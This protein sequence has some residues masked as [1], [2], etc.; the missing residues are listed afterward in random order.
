MTIVIATGNEGKIA[1]FERIF[2]AAEID[3]DIVSAKSVGIDMSKIEETGDSF[4]Q[5]A[6]IKASDA[7]ALCGLPVVADD[8]GLC[9]DAIGGEPGIYSARYSGENATDE[10]NI[11]KLLLK[12][13]DIPDEK[14]TARFYCCICAV[15]D[16]VTITAEETCEGKIGYEKKGENGFGYDPVFYVGGKS[17]A[18]IS[19]GDKDEISHRGKALRA[20]A[21]KLRGGPDA[22]KPAD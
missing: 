19:D 15:F 3:A 5:N 1:E 4:A 6:F 12:L 18:Q 9:V 8:S 17:F 22:G 14:R 16:G 10:K 21:K 7:H 11:E 2:A 13:K 20:F